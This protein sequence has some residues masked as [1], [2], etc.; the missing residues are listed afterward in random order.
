MYDKFLYHTLKD[1]KIGP[2]RGMA[3]SKT[4]RQIIAEALTV[5]LGETITP[6]AIERTYHQL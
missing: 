4:H 5:L 3:K 1:R 2:I 6:D